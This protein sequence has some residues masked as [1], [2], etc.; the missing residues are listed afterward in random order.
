MGALMYVLKML[1]KKVEATKPQASRNESAEIFVVCLGYKNPSYIDP[2]I[3]DPKYALK[4][5]EDEED[6]KMNSIKS[7]KAM[8]EKK[9]HRSGY[10]GK[11]IKNEK[12]FKDFVEATNPYQ[13]LA[14]YSKIK[15][16]TDDCKKYLEVMKCPMDH[17]LYFEDIQILGKKEIQELII[18]RNKI[19]SRLFK[20]KAEDKA[21][22]EDDEKKEVEDTKTY[23]EKKIEEMDE[24][25]TEFERARKKRTDN[26]KKKREKNELRMKMS[27][28]D[29]Q[30]SAGVRNDVEYDQRL[31]D[32]IKKNDIN[33][34]ELSGGDEE[35][36]QDDGI[37]EQEVD[38]VD[39]S[40][41]SEEDYIDM[42][43]NDITENKK[44]FIEERKE[45]HKKQEKREKKKKFVRE[46]D[47]KE[48]KKLSDGVQYVR[49]DKDA[50]TD[51]DDSDD[52]D[53]EEEEDDEENDENSDAEFFAK[54]KIEN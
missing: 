5:L 7:I 19:R 33:I 11:L 40:E 49:A 32:F 41:L 24:E 52:S 54:N 28:V 14:E 36:D 25:M 2:K 38:E 43:N 35:D 18:W 1:F 51:S 34:E 15:P 6:M 47:E 23:Q 31:F 16:N 20:K 39:L 53:D 46:E 37:P 4:Q 29:Q 10:S 45:N 17:K 48:E 9:K 8:F 30:N 26:E 44:L 42:M 13:F 27:F 21:D 50:E 12:T 3:L 22:G